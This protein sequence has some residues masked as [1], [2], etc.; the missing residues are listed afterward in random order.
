MPLQT[1]TKHFLSLL[2]KS[3]QL[4]SIATYGE[5]AALLPECN[6]ACGVPRAFGA[7]RAHLISAEV[8]EQTKGGT[9]NK[10]PKRLK[11]GMT[12]GENV[13]DKNIIFPWKLLVLHI[14]ESLSDFPF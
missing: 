9:E 10:Q 8:M 11:S 5:K 7:L 12:T 3:I 6:V 2:H 4:Y 1:F 14:D 13:K